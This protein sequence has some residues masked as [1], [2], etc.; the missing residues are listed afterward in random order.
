ML[1]TTER[2]NQLPYERIVEEYASG[3]YILY[4][5][6][7]PWDAPIFGELSV[8]AHENPNLCNE[9]LHELHIANPSLRKDAIRYMKDNTGGELFIELCDYRFDYDKDMSNFKL[10][11]V[12]KFLIS[13]QDDIDW[14]YGLTYKFDHILRD[15]GFIEEN[16]M[17]VVSYVAEETVEYIK[18][19][20][21]KATGLKVEFN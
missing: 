9:I 11:F 1:V 8:I 19:N 21:A 2:I 7:E 14:S 17:V 12:E 6:K 5:N 13:L 3:L 18:K 15:E 10:E 20:F 4:T 16:V